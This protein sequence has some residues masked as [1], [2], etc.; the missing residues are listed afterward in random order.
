MY[1]HQK[2]TR[3]QKCSKNGLFMPAMTFI[4]LHVQDRLFAKPWLHLRFFYSHWQL[5]ILKIVLRQ[6][7]KVVA[8]VARCSQYLQHVAKVQFGEYS[9]TL[10]KR[11]CCRTYPCST[12]ATFWF[13]NHCNIR[14]MYCVASATKNVPS[15]A[16]RTR[17][18][19]LT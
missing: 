1:S 6:N 9:A 11:F 17:G 15:E 7:S 3:D 13:Y 10:C 2:D 14:K 4:W 8:L 5:D 19:L 18:S 16:L 12:H